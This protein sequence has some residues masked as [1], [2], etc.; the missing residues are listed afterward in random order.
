MYYYKVWPNMR[1]VHL[2]DYIEFAEKTKAKIIEHSD[3]HNLIE[4]VVLCSSTHIKESTFFHY[5]LNYC[6][7]TDL[8]SIE[9]NI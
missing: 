3:N 9:T 6:L 4:H 7:M 8:K 2:W 1:I 5:K